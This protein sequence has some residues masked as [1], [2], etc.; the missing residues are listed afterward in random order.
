MKQSVTVLAKTSNDDLHLKYFNA[1]SAGR[2][3][4]E[5]REQM[6][7]ILV[8]DN[9]RLTR[10]LSMIKAEAVRKEEQRKER[11][12]IAAKLFLLLIFGFVCTISAV[13][14]IRYGLW[15]AAIAPIAFLV[16]GLWQVGKSEL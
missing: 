9:R 7:R 2:R 5:E 1:L 10:E 16:C 12:L 15:W 13:G 3:A 14:C 8:D 4:V 6:Q 11:I